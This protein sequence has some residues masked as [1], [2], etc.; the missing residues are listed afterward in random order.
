MNETSNAF[1]FSSCVITNIMHC[2]YYLFNAYSAFILLSFFADA[3][4]VLA[5]VDCDDLRNY[6]IHL[7]NTWARNGSLIHE[8]LEET[9]YELQMH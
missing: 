3:F 8:Y 5:H 7:S 4:C 2:Y 9:I 6:F 1:K